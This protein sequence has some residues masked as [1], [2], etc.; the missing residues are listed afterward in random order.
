MVADVWSTLELFRDTGRL[1]ASTGTIYFLRIW[2]VIF[3]SAVTQ[4][5]TEIRTLIGSSFENFE[6]KCPTFFLKFRE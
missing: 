6:F 3:R 1:D 5:R 2:K 4:D